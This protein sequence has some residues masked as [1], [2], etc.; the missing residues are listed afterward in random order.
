MAT[1]YRS[2][3]KY[4]FLFTGPTSVGRF[5]KDLENVFQVLTEYYNYPASNIHVVLGS[6]AAMPS[7][8]GAT[9]INI[10]DAG[11]LR[12]ALES[13]AGMASGPATGPEL[14]PGTWET[15]ALL[16]FT[17]GGITEASV[18][19]LV[20]D[21]GPGT[22]NVDPAWLTARLNS[23]SNCHV[24]VVVQQSFSGGLL[25]ALTG[26][27]LTQWSF[28]YACSDTQDSYGNNTL[29]SFFT[30]GWL[31][32]LKLETLPAGTPDAGK[33][34]DE[35][36]S[37]T[38][39]ANRK[40]SLE[41]AM[42]FAKQIHDSMGF[43]PL[44]TPGYNGFG[45]S[46]YPGLPEFVIR[47]G[48]PPYWWESPDI[49][50]TH[51]NHGYLPPGDLYIP[52]PV[53]ATPPYN[54]T[55]NIDVRNIGT[56]P[57]RA[58]SIGAELYKFGAGPTSVQHTACDIVPSGGILLPIDVTDIGT[59]D[60]KKETYEWN[61]PFYEPA[62]HNC[63]KAEAKL[64]C[65]DVDFTWSVPTYDF[66]GQR[67]IDEM[68]VVPPPP[69][70]LPFPNLQGFKEH[71]YG[72]QNRFDEPRKFIMVFPEKYQEYQDVIELTWFEV[73]RVRKS[74]RIPLDVVDEPVL[75]IPFS[76]KAGEKTDILL[77]VKMKPDF[78]IEDGIRLPFEILV[79]GD[80]QDDA[81]KPMAYAVDLPNYA[82]IAG[83]TVTI[84]KG[85]ST[86]KGTVLDKE[87]KPVAEAKIFIRTVNDLQGAVIT[88]DKK[89][90]YAFPD[91]N[92]DVYYIH[93]ETENCHSREQTVVLLKGKEEELKLH[94]TEEIP[95]TGKHVKVVLDK[96]RIMDDHDPCIKGKG[97]LTFTSVIV[98]DNDDSRKQV[99]RLPAK[100]VYHVSDKPGENE[101]R[102]EVTLF[103]G[104][105]ANRSLAIS[106]S[107]K[108]IDVFDP[109][110]ELN[111]YHRVFSGD[112]DTWYGQYYPSDEYL[113]REDIGDWALWY[114]I[115]RD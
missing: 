44:S 54:N 25:S 60:D 27:T 104:I 23:F 86:L 40:V 107:G 97:E 26:S 7:V 66:E 63:V 106:I 98:P 110:D 59:S 39:A 8:P 32:G 91:I 112:T 52:D 9:V 20:I 33:Y 83:F 68:T 3:D 31:R 57:V 38:E 114:R 11:E 5:I 58:Y 10:N 61:T 48:A 14:P 56:H 90:R 15:T 81:R 46:R 69:L 111:R 84:K 67:N 95:V 24:N 101:I 29:G 89:G 12:V 6:A 87:N 51:P 94:L 93:A 70:P 85:S 34:A 77:Q 71:I 75:H 105:V 76:L 37:L 78:A 103:D 42:E 92:P 1:T 47:D 16:Y 17:G 36:G 4:A 2:Q 64:L 88:T 18:S 74:E 21:D 72:I 109:D 62:T 19:K 96:I 35:L 50:L 55:I 45:G 115:V 100:G 28:T 79:E 99:T 108:E 53:A 73:A 43:G 65:S 80:W 49:Y 30:H 22:A 13:F 102:L 41:E 113:D 82:P